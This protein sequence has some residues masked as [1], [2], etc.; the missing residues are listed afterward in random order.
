MYFSL[1]GEGYPGLNIGKTKAKNFLNFDYYIYP[2]DLQENLGGFVLFQA[3]ALLVLDAGN[4]GV[5]LVLGFVI[6]NHHFMS[7]ELGMLIYIYNI[8]LQILQN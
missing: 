7:D 4:N 8:V 1:F 6:Q 3:A 5:E 2:F